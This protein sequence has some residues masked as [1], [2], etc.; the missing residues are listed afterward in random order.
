MLLLL[1]WAG[2]ALGFGALA[3]LLFAKLPSRD[4]A[5]QIA[6]AMVHRLD[7][8]AW[9]A[10]VVPLVLSYGGR[11]IGELDEG[12]IGP[13]KL[14]AMAFFIPIIL[15]ILSSTLVSPRLAEL[16]AQMGGPIE[17]FAL[18]HP[19]RAAYE[20]NH[21]IS[22]IAFFVRIAL[23]LGLGLVVEKLPRP[24]PRPAGD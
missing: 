19:L 16:R 6:G 13:A 24:A 3:P 17:G 21:R 9:I 7:T 4:L 23:A 10:F 8:L 20:T 12:P 14:W 2:A 15:T 1:L 22:N 5:G 18:D 11:W